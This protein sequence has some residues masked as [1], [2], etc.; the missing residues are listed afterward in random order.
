MHA[1][2]RS[3]Q[4][5]VRPSTEGTVERAVDVTAETAVTL[6][7]EDFEAALH[8]VKPS[9]TSAML[10]AL[11]GW[12]ASQGSAAEVVGGGAREGRASNSH[13]ASAGFSFTPVEPGKPLAFE[14]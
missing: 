9:V 10:R 7:A 1:L 3:T 11:E 13:A 4:S 8:S 12:A 5:H 14:F 6:E 2:A